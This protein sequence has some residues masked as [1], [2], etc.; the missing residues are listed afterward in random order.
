M[1]TC[2]ERNFRRF[3]HVRKLNTA[4]ERLITHYMLP[5]LEDPVIVTYITK[6]NSRPLWYT[7]DI[8]VI[9]GDDGTIVVHK[10]D[11]E[12]FVTINTNRVNCVDCIAS[13]Y[14]G[15]CILDQTEVE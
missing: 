14:Y 4:C 13:A 9:R 2:L 7:Q 5:N 10:T 6:A 1:L 11:L 3:K 12:R 15:I 8:E